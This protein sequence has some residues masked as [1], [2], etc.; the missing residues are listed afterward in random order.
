[1]ISLFFGM[2]VIAA[3]PDTNFR[4]LDF[5]EFNSLNE[6][7]RT[8][9]LRAVTSLF[10]VMEETQENNKKEFSFI[11]MLIQKATAS[12]QFYCVGGGVPVPSSQNRCG[13]SSFAN[14]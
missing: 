1:M 9:Y 4:A 11:N 13:V 7:H 14:S 10:Y 5:E 2:Q 8:Q 12:A 6:Y 3:V